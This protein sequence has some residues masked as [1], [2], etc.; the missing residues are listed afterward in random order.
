MRS[1]VRGRALESMLVLSQLAGLLTSV[2]IA[3]ALGPTG[4]GL[5]TTLAVWAQFL[6]WVACFSLDKAMVVLSRTS[7]ADLVVNEALYHARRVVR[8]TVPIVL[9]FAVVLGMR[10]FPG[11]W[12]LIGALLVALA[13]SAHSELAMGWYLAMDREDSFIRFRLSQPLLYFAFALCIVVFFRGK[14]TSL[15]TIVLAVGLVASLAIPVAVAS[16][17]WQPRAP[18][19]RSNGLRRLLR[20]AAPAQLGSVLQY[21]NSRLDLIVLPLIAGPAVVGLYSVG[22]AAS[23]LIITV[24]SA[25]ALRGIMG[26]GRRRDFAGLLSA[27]AVTIALIVTAPTVVPLLFGRKFAGAIGFVQVLLIGGL[28]GYALQAASGRLMGERRVWKL[29][30]AHGVGAFTFL[31][32]IVFTRSPLGVAWASVASYVAALG[33]AEYF[34]LTG[35]NQT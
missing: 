19:A 9:A 8:A 31:M 16:R 23:Q 33:V 18:I 25:G 12:P 10:L 32:G 21:L 24:G 2:L 7:G 34:A 29:T 28:F 13:V 1:F 14:A 3:R 6:G 22:A 17:R 20:F 26:K 15:Q 11:E 27:A 4:K 30:I 5:L 35:R